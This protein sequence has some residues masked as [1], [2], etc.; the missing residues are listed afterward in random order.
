[1]RRK[2]RIFGFKLGVTALF[3]LGLAGCI[4]TGAGHDGAGYDKVSRLGDS[5][6]AQVAGTKI[7]HS[8]VVRAAQAAQ[9]IAGGE[10]L[11]PDDPRY[12]ALMHELIDQ[13]LLRL[14]A[15]SEGLDQTDEARRRLGESRERILSTLL[16]EQ[17]LKDNVNEAALR[18]TYDAQASLRNRGDEIRARH[19]LAESEEDIQ[20]AVKALEGGADFAEL[21][22]KISI[23]RASK[24]I[25]GDLGFFTADMLTP[26]FSE[27][28]FA[29]PLDTVS[30]PFQ[31][32]Y[33]WHILE[34]KSRRKAEPASFESMQ[35]QLTQYLTYQEVEK[36]IASLRDSADITILT[37][38]TQNT[39]EVSSE[40]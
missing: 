34:V 3:A 28:A 26:E 1:M 29:L 15:I 13:R 8:D 38:S 16:I 27:V 23:D 37:N 25:G 39:P 12:A 20:K 4:D 35:G 30:E 5:E 19:I 24:D 33:G 40:P 31:S 36:L 11:E 10:T 32:V 7:Y 22:A 6:A 14:A 21:A 18:E 2:T 17:R 9:L